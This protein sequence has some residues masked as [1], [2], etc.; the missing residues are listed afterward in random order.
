MCNPMAIQAAVMI[1][2]AAYSADQQ[3][4][5][6]K[7]QRGV[8]EYNAQVAENEAEE[9]RAKGVEEEN[10][11]RRRT[12]ELLSKQRAQLGAANVDLGSGSALQLQEDTIALGEADALRIRSNTDAQYESLQS[13]SYLT[14]NQG[15]NA[16]QAGKGAAFGTLL[17]G[18]GSAMG[19]GVADKWFTPTSSASVLAGSPSPISAGGV[20]GD[21]LVGVA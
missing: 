17:Q 14:K 13:Q 2:G 1:A 5:Q 16:E 15:E 12:A 18:A 4:K 6:G 20:V 11:Q 3:Q 19:T 10:L 21:P 8:A 7:Y 9:V